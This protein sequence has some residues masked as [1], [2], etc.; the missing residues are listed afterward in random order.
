M[1]QSKPKKTNP[2]FEILNAISSKQYSWSELSDDAR[3]KYSQ[4]MINRFLCSYDYLIPLAEQLSTQKMD[5]ESH[6][7]IL[8]EYVQHT[9]HYFNYNLWKGQ[10]DIDP[11][12]L[13]A[14]MKQYNIGQVEAKRYNSYLNETQR[15]S[16]L[17]KWRDYLTMTQNP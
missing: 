15:N 13:N 2:L 11:M 3:N 1:A 14:I 7:N 6:Y 12:L 8:L 9:K 10:E 17:D 16:I 4:F 5:N